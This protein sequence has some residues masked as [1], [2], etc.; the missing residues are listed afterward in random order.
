V[1]LVVDSPEAL[2]EARK[3]LVSV[4][5]RPGTPYPKLRKFVQPIYGR[6]AVMDFRKWVREVRD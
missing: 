1:R 4:G 2:E 5:L 3:L 6:D